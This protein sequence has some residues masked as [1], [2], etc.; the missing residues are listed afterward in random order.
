MGCKK[1]ISGVWHS[2]TEP[3][4]WGF[5]EHHFK[6]TKNHGSLLLASLHLP[7]A[8]LENKVCLE[9]H[10]YVYFHLPP[11]LLCEEATHTVLAH[12]PIHVQEAEHQ[13]QTTHSLSISY[14]NFPVSA[15]AAERNSLHVPIFHHFNNPCIF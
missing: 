2:T 6:R 3:T 5:P 1:N 14:C 7:L 13:K 12:A 8:S 11:T 10:R 4:A 9:E 15:A